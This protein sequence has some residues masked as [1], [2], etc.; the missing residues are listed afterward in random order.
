MKGPLSVCVLVEWLSVGT[1]N[2]VH[3]TDLESCAS[4][5]FYFPLEVPSKMTYFFIHPTYTYAYGSPYT[6]LGARVIKAAMIAQE[7][8]G[9]GRK[10]LIWINKKWRGQ[11]KGG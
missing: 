10:R 8:D 2:S 6:V 4:R 5:F 9:L 1:C 11:G 7:S 3:G